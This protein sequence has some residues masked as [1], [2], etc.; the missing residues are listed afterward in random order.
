MRDETEYQYDIALSFAGEDR[1]IV[2]DLATML[3]KAR[4]RVFYDE[5]ETAEL[6][7]KDLY[8]HLQ[9]VYR[10]R[11]QYCVIFVSEAYARKLWTRHE[12]QQAQARA[13]R[14]SQEYILPV[15]LDD[16]ELPG[17]NPT[18]G[19]VDLRR[20]SLDV[21]NALIIKKLYGPG[22][23]PDNLGEL[24]WSGE[25]VEWRGQQVASFWPDKMRSVQKITHYLCRVP[26][27]RYGDESSDWQAGKY[28]C[29]DCAAV[30]GEYHLPGCDVEE[31]P[32]CHG[33]ALGCEC[34]EGETWPDEEP[35]A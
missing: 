5:Y 32:L 13:F 16:T 30:K 8:Q 29:H 33:Q 22:A 3:S 26:R 31:C 34:I 14:E 18:I 12:L 15:R 6:W 4:I 20:H 10:D 23:H 35:S 24:T 28:A 1:S 9:A 27:I 25:R 7:G 2:D 21:L 11:A 17:L 19:Y